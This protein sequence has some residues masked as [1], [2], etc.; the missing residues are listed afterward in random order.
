MRRGG[1]KSNRVVMVNVFKADV[2]DKLTKTQIGVLELRC[3]CP[4]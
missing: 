2:A 4:Q 3:A 1:I